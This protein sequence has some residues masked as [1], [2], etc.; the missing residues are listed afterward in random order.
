M[1]TSRER[2]GSYGI[3]EVRVVIV[4]LAVVGEGVVA[5]K[6]GGEGIAVVYE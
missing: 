1:H 3:V 6:V 5:V 2:S 4:V